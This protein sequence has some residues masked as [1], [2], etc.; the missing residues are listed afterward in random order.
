MF[1]FSHNVFRKFVITVPLRLETELGKSF[2]FSY[3]D[4]NDNAPIISVVQPTV[5]ELE[6][7]V[8]YSISQNL[9]RTLGFGISATDADAQVI[10]FS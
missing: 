1:F 9:P 2:F 10:H 7:F 6:D 5:T 4:V 3:Q 8:E